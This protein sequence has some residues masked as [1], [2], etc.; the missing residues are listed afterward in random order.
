MLNENLRGTLI[1]SENLTVRPLEIE[2]TQRNGTS[3]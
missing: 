3:L 2:I 1:I